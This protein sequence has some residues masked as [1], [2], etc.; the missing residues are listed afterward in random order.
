MVS[1]IIETNGAAVRITEGGAGDPALV[2]LHY[3]GGSA[4]TWQRVSDRLGGQVRWVAVDQRGWGGSIAT[5]RRYDLAA[6]ADDVEG[7]VR[8]ID[9]RRYVLVGH[10][11]GGKVALIVAARCGRR[12]R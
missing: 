2:L 11:M 4:R 6:M 8:A 1:R 7:V 3:W 5:D 9:L 12:S 10:S